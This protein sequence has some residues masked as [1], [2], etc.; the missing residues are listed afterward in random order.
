MAAQSAHFTLAYTGLG[1]SPDGGSTWLLPRL[2]G[3]R[4]AQEMALTNRR[5]AAGEAAEMGLVTRVVEDDA[6]MVEAEA[7]ARKMAESAVHA[8]G[9]TRN[10]LLSSFSAT[11]ETQM[12]AEARAIA[13]AGRDPESREGIS[14][15]ADRRPPRFI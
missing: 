7:L 8:V 14:A 6:L 15:Y 1:L 4:K 12:E 10:L 13:E 9:R 11:L 2:V 3:L 5:V